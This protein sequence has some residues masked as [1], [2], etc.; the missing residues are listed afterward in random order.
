MKNPTDGELHR[1]GQTQSRVL[2][3]VPP[4]PLTSLPPLCPQELG[5]ES[6]GACSDFQ[7]VAGCGIRCLV[8]S[9]DN[10][11][12]SEDDNNQRNGILVQIGDT[13]T[14]TATHPLIMDP[15]PLSTQDRR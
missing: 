4:L 8:S 9:V 1:A 14:P 12:R 7:T 3:W 10:L 5:S 6:L 11:P 15:E 13:R 2:R